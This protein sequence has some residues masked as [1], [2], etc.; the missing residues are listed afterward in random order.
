MR[1]LITKMNELGDPALLEL[2]DKPLHEKGKTLHNALTG[3]K[4]MMVREPRGQRH[5]CSTMYLQRGYSMG[6]QCQDFEGW[7]DDQGR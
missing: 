5:Q 1:K 7:S 4:R 6:I 3:A 2:K